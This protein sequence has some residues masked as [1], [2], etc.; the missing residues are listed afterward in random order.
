VRLLRAHSPPS[1]ARIPLLQSRAFPSFNRAHSPPSIARSHSFLFIYYSFIMRNS[2]SSRPSGPIASTM[3]M[4]W[5]VWMTTAATTT[6]HLKL[7][8]HSFAFLFQGCLLFLHLPAHQHQSAGVLRESICSNTCVQRLSF[9]AECV[10]TSAPPRTP[11]SQE[12]AL[13]CCCR[14]HLPAYVT[15]AVQNKR[16]SVRCI[17]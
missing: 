9:A 16:W 3:T 11:D 10:F 4:M 8:L 13:C 14:C 1:I 2:L 6:E 12:A 17:V 7:Q 15:R 5:A